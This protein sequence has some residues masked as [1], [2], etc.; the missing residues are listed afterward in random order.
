MPVVW[1]NAID[2]QMRRPRETSPGTVFKRTVQEASTKRKKC[3]TE[4]SF[5]AE[6]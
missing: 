3:Y 6:T 1:L 2:N 5:N 4:G